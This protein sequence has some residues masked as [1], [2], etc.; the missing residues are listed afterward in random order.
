[1]AVA[2]FPV[3][4]VS[5]YDFGAPLPANG[6][7]GSGQSFGWLKH[8]GVDY[9]TKAGQKIKAPWAG[10]SKFETG[11]VGY[12]NRLTITFENG[13]KFV[14]GHVASGISGA[15]AQGQEIG[16]TGANVGSARGAVTLVEVRNPQGVAVNPHS[17][18]D[19]LL[20]N[21]PGATAGNLFGIGSAIMDQ[22][23]AAPGAIAKPLVDAV[24]APAK[25]A[26]RLLGWTT[27]TKL[28]K[29]FFIGTGVLMM[30]AGA[31]IYFKGDQIVVAVQEGSKDVA[32]AATVAAA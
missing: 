14:F 16:V 13:W 23:I 27:P 25:L 9:G 15:V 22:L 26:G 3:A 1:L 2:P 6:W 21:D 5:G 29:G 28:W 20:K 8:L 11:L 32:K 17:Y 24:T 18:I 4:P 31:I 12:G 30:I 10:V 7:N 19:P